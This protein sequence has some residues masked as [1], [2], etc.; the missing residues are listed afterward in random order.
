M[1]GHGRLPEYQL[2]G[3]VCQKL[4]YLVQIFTGL[5]EVLRDN[6]EVLHE[7]CDGC[8]RS[9]DQ[10]RSFLQKCIGSLHRKF[11]IVNCGLDGFFLFFDDAIDSD[12]GFIHLVQAAIR[13]FD[14]GIKR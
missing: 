13:T 10:G 8:I 4:Q 3:L 11:K 12:N 5:F 2:R 9:V 6:Q 14:D 7:I 1:A